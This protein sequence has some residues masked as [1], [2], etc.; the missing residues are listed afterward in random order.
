MTDD[1]NPLL[2]V[3]LVEDNS[4]D[5]ASLLRALRH[6]NQGIYIT[7]ASS[8]SAACLQ[9]TSH[10]FDVI[11]AEYELHDG[12]ALAI[13]SQINAMPSD[14]PAVIIIG[15]YSDDALA[16]QCILTGAQAYLIKDDI[17]PGSLL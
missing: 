17:R 16:E 15:G 5:R 9:L 6:H 3:L 7:E 11:L 10:Q 14:R 1:A 13:L 12:N 2:K 4:L 8:V